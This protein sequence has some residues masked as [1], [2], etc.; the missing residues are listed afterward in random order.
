M[1][2]LKKA[3]DRFLELV[4]S[5]LFLV[6]VGVTTW[7]VITRYILHNPSSI[8][9]EFVKFSLIWL[10][11]LSAAYVVGKNG[12]ISITLL[13]SRLVENK[14]IIVDILI[15]IS[16]LAFGSIVMMYGGI[17]T[18]LMT[19]DQIS[20]A[21]HLSMGLIYLSLPISGGLFIFYSILNILDLIE[22]KK[23]TSES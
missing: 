23:T 7:Q 2:L 3:F 21:L 19:V 14:R 15:Q 10:S 17:K 11:L 5:L 22:S 12:H 9:E 6:M 1:K 13:S 4:V 20:P 18:V 8:T 16:F